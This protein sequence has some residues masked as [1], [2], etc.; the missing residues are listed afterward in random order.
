MNVKRWLGVGCSLV[1]ALG[2]VMAADP[3]CVRIR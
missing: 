2:V 3:L 1:L